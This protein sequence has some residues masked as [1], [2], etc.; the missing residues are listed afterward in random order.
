VPDDVDPEQGRPGM[1]LWKIFVAAMLRHCL[2]IGVHY[3]DVG[4]LLKGRYGARHQAPRRYEVHD[5]PMHPFHDY[6]AQHLDGR[7][8]KCSI[9][10]FYDPREEFRPFFEQEL[11]VEEADPLV[12]YLPNV[13]RDRSGPVLMELELGGD[14]YEPQL[15]RLAQN[16]LRK[17][18]T[19]GQ[20]D[21]NVASD[22]VDKPG[23]TRADFIAECVPAWPVFARD[24]LRS[25][26][27]C[28]SAE[29]RHFPFNEVERAR[30]WILAH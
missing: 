30:E 29:V 5:L 8:R 6:L 10:V 28:R 25:P 27:K 19:D 23:T 14:C 12:R 21:E 18:F 16:V 3:T 22:R 17:R 2:K 4:V 26:F 24:R 13:Q 9:I 11:S 15:R 7:L 1:E 20:I